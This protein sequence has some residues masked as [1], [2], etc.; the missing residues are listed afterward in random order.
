MVDPDQLRYF[1]R[2]EPK[3]V[4]RVKLD[5]LLPYHDYPKERLNDL[6]EIKQSMQENG[7]DEHYPVRAVPHPEKPGFY[8]VIDGH[9]RIES[10]R[11]VLAKKTPGGR[12]NLPRIPVIVDDLN[13]EELEMLSKEDNWVRTKPNLGPIEPEKP[14]YCQ[15]C[16]TKLHDED[17]FC[18]ECG[19][20][21]CFD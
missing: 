4:I 11:E 3:K 16:G 17:K 20:Q 21:V 9:R 10:A 13:D 19:N 2:P 7:F 1:E 5:R 14:N 8:E 12:T 18:P 15:K 6:S